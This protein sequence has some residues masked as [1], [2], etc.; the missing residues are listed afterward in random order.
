MKWQSEYKSKLISADEAV[1][2]IKSGN[3]V[4]FGHAVG[5]PVALIDA[6]VRNADAYEHVEIFHMVAMGKSEY[7]KP[8]YEKNFWHNSIFLGGTTRQAIAEGRGDYTPLFFYEYPDLFRE[9]LRPDAALFQVSPP[10]EH[11]YCSFG[12]SVDY[13]KPAAECSKIKIAQVNKFMPYTYG[14]SFI[15][16]SDLDYIVEHDAPLIELQPAVLSEIEKAIGRNVASLVRNGDCLQLGIGAIPDAVLAGLGDKNDLGLHTEM[17]SDGAVDMLQKGIITNKKKNF[18]TGKSIAN[19]LMG[20]CKLYEFVNNNPSVE[21]YPVD[22]VNNPQI[23]CQNDNL[24]SINACVQVDLMGQVVSDSIGYK[25]ISGTG[26]QVDFVRAANMS[27][28]G[29]S[30]IAMPSMTKGISKV[31]PV[32]D[33]GAAVTTSRCDVGYVVTEHGIA[34]LKGKTLRDR[35]RALIAIAHP[36]IRTDLISVFEKR[37]HCKF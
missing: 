28:G 1:K 24:V 16:I 33:E 11:G 36:D 14:D 21:M 10:N 27:K 5:E 6:M 17:F 35:A 22:F 26:G 2:Y 37:F 25:Q 15:H 3:K 34:E 32:I 31:V 19:F 8:E 12:V 20:T 7:C 30:I 29:R 13:T 23:A 18:H 9:K 4:V